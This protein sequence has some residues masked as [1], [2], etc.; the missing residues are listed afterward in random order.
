[1]INR[2]YRAYSE[3][4]ST[5]SILEVFNCLHHDQSNRIRSYGTVRR[6]TVPYYFVRYAVSY[7]IIR[8]EQLTIYSIR[9]LRSRSLRDGSLPHKDRFATFVHSCSAL[10]ASKRPLKKSYLKSASLITP[11]SRRNQVNPTIFEICLLYKT[12]CNNNKYLN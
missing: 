8:C 3:S 5:I 12:T 4:I 2:Y 9:A 11:F 1:M 7:V 10:R 6:V